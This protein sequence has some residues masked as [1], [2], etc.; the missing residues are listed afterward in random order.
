MNLKHGKY[1]TPTYKSWSEMKSRCGNPKRPDY[2]NV[3]YC[4]E[5]EDFTTFLADMGE[6]PEGTSLDRIDPQGDYCKENCRWADNHTQATNKTNSRY[7]T[8]NG[9]RKHISEWAEITG[10]KRSTISARI[11]AY[12]WSVEEALTK[13]AGETIGRTS[14][15]RK[16]NH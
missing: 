10:I 3:S 4:K 12:G 8:F 13:K 2:V 16:D 9:E 1:G 15:V 7:I 5:W 14:H 11:L 6:R